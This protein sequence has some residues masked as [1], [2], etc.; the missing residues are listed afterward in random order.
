MSDIDPDK[1][2]VTELRDELKARGLDTKGVKAVLV[3]RLK[4]ALSD[5]HG[6]GG[7]ERPEREEATEE[8]QEDD[9]AAE[10]EEESQ[11]ATAGDGGDTG[12]QDEEE[13][14]EE[15]QVVEAE[16]EGG[17][18]E[19][20]T[21]EEK[22]DEE[23]VDEEPEAKEEGMAQEAEENGEG[24]AGVE[25]GTAGEGEGE[26]EEEMEMPDELGEEFR[27]IDETSQDED[28]QDERGSKRKRSRSRSRDRHRGRRSR[29]RERHR[30][31]PA[32]KIEMD[33]SSWESLTSF[34]LDRYNCD[35]NLRIQD[36]GLK[37]CPLTVE[38]FA[39]MWAGARSMYGVRSGKVAYEAKLLENLNVDHLPK[40][41]TNPHVLRVGWSVDDTSLQLGEEPLSYGY[42]GTGKAS[43]DC[44]FTDFGQTFTA[45]DIITAY[46]DM[47]SDPVTM[48]YSKNGEDLGVC[49]EVEKEKLE[50]KA[51]F[52]HLLTKNTEFECNFG[53]REEPFFPLK[54]GYIFINSVAEEER[55]RGSCP[56]AQKEDCEIIMM[57][58]LPGAGKTYWAEKHAGAN[59]EKRYF[60]LGTNNIIDKMKVMGLPRKKN[61]SGR[62]DVLI[63]KATKCLNRMIEIA[64]RKKRNYI[65]DQTNVYASARRRKMQPFEGFQRK[66]VV[67][68]PT[69]EEFKVRVEKREKEEGKEIPEKAVLEMKANFSLPEVGQ[70][71]DSVEFSEAEHV[72]PED[73]EK[74][75]EKYKKEARDQLPPPEKRFRDS[76]YSDRGRR[77]FREFR[78]RGGYRGGFDRDRY[79]ARGGFREDR[80]GGFSSRPYPDRRGGYAPRGASFDS[81]SWGRNDN[82]RFDDRRSYGSGSSG[83]GG[84]GGG[85]G[86]GGYRSGSGYQGQRSSGGYYGGGGSSGGGGGGGG[87][88]GYK[89]W[90][91]QGSWGHQ[92]S[93]GSGQ[94]QFSGSSG[95]RNYGSSWNQGG[96]SWG[97][98]PSYW[99]GG[100]SS[101]SG[102]GSGGGGSS[103]YNS[104]WG[105]GY[106]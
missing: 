77:D 78:P 26:G 98:Q 52:P 41:E 11:E 94:G 68:V 15:Y 13:E 106:K 103:G 21:V 105:G 48:S 40:D 4:Q 54:E 5:E 85:S 61:Y 63:D 23:Q 83:G 71:F 92:G 96:G 31:P 12:A 84:G 33:D 55:V 44:K 7:E 87:S 97:G 14:E 42:G 75:V 36:D 6:G 81:R 16:E 10:E 38:G 28:G 46:L 66:A 102:Y 69:D 74:L 58:G 82:R 65:L 73:A 43:T 9:A 35:L 89:G 67:V 29:S 79:G 30:S 57:V 95:Y 72:T 22:G 2:K 64:A 25:E 47:D 32:R 62:W 51:L 90:G 93:W 1:L 19:E 45:G 88:G 99:S 50:D 37:A 70:L 59:K 49:F 39:F 18:E 53:Q 3:E 56:P 17:E 86:G 76:R 24:D 91:S 104:G 8:S 80:R 101:G 100:G 60:V 20:K 27:T 34:Q